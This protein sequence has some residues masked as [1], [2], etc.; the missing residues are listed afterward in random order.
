MEKF[1]KGLMG[2]RVVL[3]YPTLHFKNK[4]TSWG[5]IWHHIDSFP[6]GLYS[7]NILSFGLKIKRTFF[8]FR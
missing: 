6:R 5:Q 4:V 1:N 7:P 8:F 3:R 2:Q